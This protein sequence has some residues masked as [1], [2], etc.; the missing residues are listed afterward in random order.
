[1]KTLSRSLFLLLLPLALPAE[2]LL[3]RRVLC[4]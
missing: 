1:M 2:E 3:E 4:K